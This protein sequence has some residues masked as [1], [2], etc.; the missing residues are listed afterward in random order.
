MEAYNRKE[1]RTKTFYFWCSFLVLMAVTTAAMYSFVWASFEQK[2]A[3][4]SKLQEHRK[5]INTQLTVQEKVDSLYAY[6]QNL[7]AG[8][9]DNYLFLEKIISETR[10]NTLSFINA[11]SSQKFPAYNSILDDLNTL[12]LTKDTIIKVAEKER[13]VK[14]E[15]FNCMSKNTD[16]RTALSRQQRALSN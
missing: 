6:M 12:A 14:T 1:I 13:S 10:A 7:D 5:I 3:Y 16:I 9:V 4:I 15:L 11:D 2:A 8:K